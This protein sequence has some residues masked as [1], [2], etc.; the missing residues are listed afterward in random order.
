MNV[1]AD[2]AKL[3]AALRTVAEP[4][5]WLEA[6][7]DIAPYL[8]D[9]RHLY[10]GRAL[11]VALPRSVAEVSRLLAWCNTQRVGVVP[12]GGNT[13]YCGGATP[14]ESGSQLVI[15]LHRLNRIRQLDAATTR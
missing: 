1:G 2:A 7:A 10:Q 14:D 11:G 15:G 12:Q 13:S 8:I 5:T 6:E 9:H 3:R 4:G